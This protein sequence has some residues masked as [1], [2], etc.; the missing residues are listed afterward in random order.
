M[1]TDDRYRQISAAHS[2]LNQSYNYHHSLIKYFYV[3]PLWNWIHVA[4]VGLSLFWIKTCWLCC[5]HHDSANQRAVRGV[6]PVRAW[7]SDKQLTCELDKQRCAL[8]GWGSAGFGDKTAART[9]STSSSSPWPS[10]GS[11]PAS[12][13]SAPPTVRNKLVT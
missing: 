12:P 1:F 4:P 2:D 10:S 13:S 3:S 6:W 7:P 8:I 5:S 11:F 9:F